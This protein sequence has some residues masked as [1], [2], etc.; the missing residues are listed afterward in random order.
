M[1]FDTKSWTIAP[2]LKN[3]LD[4]IRTGQTPDLHGWMVKI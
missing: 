1:H 3:R 4:A 2:A